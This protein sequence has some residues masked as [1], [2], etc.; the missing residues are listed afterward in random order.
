MFTQ[1]FLFA[2]QSGRSGL[3][4]VAGDVKRDGK[5]KDDALQDVLHERVNT[6]LGEAVKER[7]EEDAAE[8]RAD[9]AALA[10]CQRHAADDRADD[11]VKFVVLTVGDRHRVEA[12]HQDQTAERRQNAAEQERA[13]LIALDV[14]AGEERRLTRAADRVEV[15]AHT[16]LG[17][18]ELRDDID[19]EQEDDAEGGGLKEVAAAEE[20]DALRHIGDGHSLRDELCKTVADVLRAERCDHGG[21]ADVGDHQT[22]DRAHGETDGEHDED[23]KTGCHAVVDHQGRA[24]AARKADHTTQRQV[25]VARQEHDGLT[26]GDDGDRRALQQDVFPVAPRQ[27]VLRAELGVGDDREHDDQDGD[28]NEAHP[29]LQQC[30]DAFGVEGCR[31]VCIHFFFPPAFSGSAAWSVAALPMVC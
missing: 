21:D 31:F 22:V 3:L 12:G 9:D 25:K 20:H 18:D 7:V 5:H 23:G 4:L 29:V 30:A 16:G 11:G 19:C 1:P 10:A 17:G 24:H 13:E 15:T 8:H 28:A 2:S 27:E 26:E 6:H 14:D